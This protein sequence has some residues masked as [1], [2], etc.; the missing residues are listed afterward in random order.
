[1]NYLFLSNKKGT[2]DTQ[3]MDDTQKTLSRVKEARHKD[4]M[5][6]NFIK[7]KL[8]QKNLIYNDRKQNSGYWGQ[9]GWED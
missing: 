2:S 1:M 6:Y 5:K 8:K 7:K 4:Y 3:N 9:V